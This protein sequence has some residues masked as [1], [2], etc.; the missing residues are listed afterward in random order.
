[1][2]VQKPS[3]KKAKK[4]IFKFLIFFCVKCSN[5]IVAVA[6]Q[7]V[8][9]SFEAT[10]KQKIYF[11]TKKPEYVSKLALVLNEQGYKKN[12]YVC[13]FYDECSSSPKI[14]AQLK[15]VRKQK[16]LTIQLKNIKENERYRIEQSTIF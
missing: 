4:K 16:E 8:G 12:L 15:L 10:F 7:Y 11:L 3:I 14:P 9:Q 2:K 13:P 5:K 1:L 6:N